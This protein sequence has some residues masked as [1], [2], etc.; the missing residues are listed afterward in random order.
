MLC[1]VISCHVTFI[2]YLFN[3]LQ[4]NSFSKS[5]RFSVS[6]IGGESGVKMHV[7]F[8]L[9]YY[10]AD[11]SGRQI[12]ACKPALTRNTLWTQKRQFIFILFYFIFIL[13]EFSYLIIVE[14]TN[15][16]TY[17]HSY[18]LSLGHQWLYLTTDKSSNILTDSRQ[19]VRPQAT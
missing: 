17:C 4:C 10:R 16:I 19:M 7:R 5:G 8:A 6:Q 13:L 14:V 3:L 11:K 15:L 2:L 12:V 9:R 18:S 1:H